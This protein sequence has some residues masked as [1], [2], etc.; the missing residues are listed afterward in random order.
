[1]ADDYEA[2]AEF[3]DLI[4]LYRMRRDAP[5]YVELAGR[6]PGAVLELGCGTGR[7]ALPVARAG[8][9]L[10]GLD[11]SPA[12]LGIFRR[13][14]ASEPREIASRIKLVL[15]DMR[16]FD[17]GERF[18]LITTPF[19][20]FQHMLTVEDQKACLACVRR[21]LAPGGRF[22]LDLAAPNFSLLAS[23]RI[24]EVFEDADFTDP[25]TGDRI[26]RSWKYVEILRHRQ[27]NVVEFTYRRIGTG[28]AERSI[29]HRVAIRYFFRFEVEH[30]LALC[31]FRVEEMFSDYDFS[32]FDGTREMITVCSAIP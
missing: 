18:A 1:M 15:G 28:G 16:H 24:G 4:P 27:V 9:K 22:V 26:I 13:K 17:L 6:A 25:A 32:P 23:Q 19:R 2:C 5:F 14:L 21:H 8:A 29:S 12:M 10:T 3:Y 30:L 11:A 20:S 31:G 7:I